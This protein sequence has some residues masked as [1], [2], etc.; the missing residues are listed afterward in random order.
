MYFCDQQIDTSLPFPCQILS[1]L[2]PFVVLRHKEELKTWLHMSSRTMAAW[3]ETSTRLYLVET[4][5]T[6]T[7]FKETVGE[8]SFKNQRSC[9]MFIEFQGY[10]MSHFFSGDV[11]VIV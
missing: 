7:H 9:K 2:S 1:C 5:A 8:C 6:D 3:E 10:H 4:I 11:H